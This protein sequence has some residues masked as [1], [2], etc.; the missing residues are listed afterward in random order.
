MITQEYERIDFKTILDILDPDLG[1]D[2][3]QTSYYH[4]DFKNKLLRKKLDDLNSVNNRS[5]IN[6]L[7]ESIKILEPYVGD[8]DNYM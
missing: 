2:F 3:K 8:S 4:N 7:F 5:T 6:T 1:V